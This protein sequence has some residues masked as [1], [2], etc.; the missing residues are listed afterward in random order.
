MV[1]YWSALLHT[2]AGEQGTLLLG[3]MAIAILR[4]TYGSRAEAV[5]ARRLSLVL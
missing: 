2:Q 4:A 3:R 5:T 1:P